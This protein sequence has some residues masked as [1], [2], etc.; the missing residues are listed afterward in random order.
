MLQEHPTLHAVKASSHQLIEIT[1]YTFYIVEQTG[2]LPD[3]H[4]QF[5]N[6]CHIFK[7]NYESGA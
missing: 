4:I 1:M 5:W 7:R 2:H 6:H 3:T